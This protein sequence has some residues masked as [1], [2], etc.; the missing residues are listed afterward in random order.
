MFCIGLMSVFNEICHLVCKLMMVI[1]S[2]CLTLQKNKTV[3]KTVTE[4]RDTHY[5]STN[6]VIL[7]F[8]S[9]AVLK[10]SDS[11]RRNELKMKV[12]ESQR[13]VNNSNHIYKRLSE[14]NCT[15]YLRDDSL[16]PHSCNFYFVTEQTSPFSGSFCTLHKCNLLLKTEKQPL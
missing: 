7:Y 11:A 6:S 9:G 1:S 3:L 15:M 14:S 8:Q 12:E 2:T 5:F 4:Q 10:S 16:R 13:R